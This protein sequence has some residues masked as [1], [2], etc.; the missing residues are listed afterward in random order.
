MR[1][2]T[3]KELVGPFKKVYFVMYRKGY[4]HYRTTDGF[5]FT[6]PADD[7]GDG[8]F[9]NEDK[10][11]LFMRYIRRQLAENEAGMTQQ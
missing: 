7:C 3:L 8:V 1:T 6:V 2:Y 10:A 4:L 11:I 5:E 9:L